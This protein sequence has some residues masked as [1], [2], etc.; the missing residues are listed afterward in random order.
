MEHYFLETIASTHEYVIEGLKEG[1]LHP[2]FIVVAKEQTQGKGSR[3]NQWE[4]GKGNLFLT[5]CVL[6]KHL[7][8]DLSL[9][10]VSV[11]FA[12]MAK[13]VLSDAGSMAWVKWPNDIYVGEKKIGGVM[14]VKT[15]EKVIVSMGI[16][17][18]SSSPLFGVLDVPLCP[19]IFTQALTQKMSPLPPWKNIFSK[20]KLEFEHSKISTCHI[21][22]EKVSLKEAILCDDGSIQ[23]GNKKVYSLR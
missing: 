5:L 16:N 18:Q 8:N 1:L 19:K 15:G 22:G 10:S 11:Y 6:E 20:Y 3:G 13:E 7:P 4:S 2:P 9:A 23:I 17:L 12:M 14:S 21:G